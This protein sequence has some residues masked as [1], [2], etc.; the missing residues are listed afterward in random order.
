[1]YRVEVPWTCHLPLRHH[2]RGWRVRIYSRNRA[3]QRVPG[4]SV[5]GP[6]SRS[7]F[8][9]MMLSVEATGRFIMRGESRLGT[10]GVGHTRVGDD[11]KEGGARSGLGRGS[12]GANF[13]GERGQSSKQ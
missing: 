2:E 1:M 3:Q 8:R 6:R 7:D 12:E 11:N 4:H 10:E 5:P 9:R 13:A